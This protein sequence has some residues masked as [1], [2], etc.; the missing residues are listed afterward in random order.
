MAVHLSKSVLEGSVFCRTKAYLKLKGKKDTTDEYHRFCT[1]LAVDHASDAKRKLMAG[2][3]DSEVS[4]GSTATLQ[5]HRQGPLLLFDTTLDDGVVSLRCD[6][7]EKVPG[8]S[9]LGAHSYLPVLYHLGER[10]RAPQKRLL[11]L[12]GAVLCEVQRKEPIDGV[13]VYGRQYSRARV[14]LTSL[15]HSARNTLTDL[16]DLSATDVSPPLRLNDH[17]PACEFHDI[18]RAEAQAADHLSLLGKISESEIRR[19]NSKG[20]FTVTQLSYTFRPRRKPKRACDQSHPYYFALQALAIRSTMTYVFTKPQ[21]PTAPVRV[22]FD[23]E[24]D[25]ENASAYLLGALV[26]GHGTMQQHSFWIDNPDDESRLLRD[27]LSLAADYPDC[28]V[29]HY[30][31]YDRSFLQRMR[32]AARV[33]NPVD[34]LLQK[35]V[36]VLSLIHG[37]IYFP[38]YSNGLKDIGAHLGCTWSDANASGLQSVMWRR[39]WEETRDHDVKQRLITYNAEDCAALKTVT[40]HIYDICRS[41]PTS[42][43]ELKSTQRPDGVMQVDSLCSDSTSKKWGDPKFLLEHFQYVNRCAWFDYQ[44]E[45]VRAR[46]NGRQD[47]SGSGRRGKYKRSR[48]LRP[49]K[50]VEMRAR[51]CPY[52]ESNDL[53]RDYHGVSSKRAYDLEMLKTGIRRRVIKYFAAQHRCRTCGKVF[54]PPTYKRKKEKYLHTLKS[55][56]MY[57]HVVNRMTF[58]NLEGIFRECFGLTI[59]SQLIHGFKNSL[60]KYYRGTYQRLLKNLLAGNVL[61]CDETGVRLQ[62]DKGYVWVLA[63]AQNVLFMF[64]STRRGDFLQEMLEQYRGVLVSDFYRAYD[65]PSCPQQKCLVHLIRDLNNDLH[66]NRYDDEFRALTK[67]FGEVLVSVVRTVDRYGLRRRYLKKHKRDVARFFRELERQEYQS[68]V[69]RKYQ[70]RLTKYR[71]K[72][73]LFLDYDDVPWNNNNAEHAVKHFAKYRMIANGRVRESGIADYLVLLSIHQTCVYRGVSFLQFLLSGER[74][75]DAYC[76]KRDQPRGSNR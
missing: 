2:I 70:K 19:H 23:V 29:F 6:C 24:G 68:V 63:N 67:S 51:K 33:K 18:C 5:P 4:L 52:C 76:E 47:P 74:D 66:Q 73:F 75:L 65:S 61:H 50:Q 11:A 1:Q 71:D 64:K 59:S 16:V 12:Y 42:S 72:L 20:I 60:A 41:I 25:T 58:K 44:T 55:W 9:A 49:T 14:R 39:R 15:L 48:K 26:V 22:Y 8:S 7:L 35:S 69:A 56:A 54:V 46:R 30:G 62:K 37:N 57:Q 31:Q 45:R 13:I 10:I 3:P 43:E 38:T 34:A 36:N 53:G 27:F 28:R 21:L 17:C 32:A 40:E